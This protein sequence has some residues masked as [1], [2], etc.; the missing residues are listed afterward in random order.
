MLNPSGW[1]GAIINRI[2]DCGEG[3]DCK[4]ESQPLVLQGQ[5]IIAVRFC[6]IVSLFSLPDAHYGPVEPLA[7]VFWGSLNVACSFK[8]TLSHGWS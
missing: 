6:L 7:G 4:E 3:P 1:S 5:I 8:M 2:C